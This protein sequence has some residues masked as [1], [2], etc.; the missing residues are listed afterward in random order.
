[1]EII[2]GNLLLA[3]GQVL[4]VVLSTFIFLLMGRVIISW[5][6]ADRYNPI[7]RF[8]ILSTEPPLSW[9]RKILP[10][11]PGPI[12]FSPLVLLL[13]IYFLQTFLVATIIDFGAKLKMMSM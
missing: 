2:L 12:D 10:R 8:L 6:N 5:V 7:V 13:V 1:M 11:I 4:G 9:V 3:V